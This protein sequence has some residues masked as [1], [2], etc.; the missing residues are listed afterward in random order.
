MDH[1]GMSNLK[2]MIGQLF[3]IG[4]EGTSLSEEE[5]NL[6]HE[7]NVGFVILFSRNFSSPV[8]LRKL[9]LEIHKLTSPPPAIFIDQEGGPIVRLGESGSTVIS[10]MGLAATGKKKNAKIAGKLIG[11]DMR[12]LGIDG[13]FAPVLD[14]NSKKDN[15]VIGIRSFSDD[16]VIVSEYGKEFYRGLKKVKILGCGKHFPGHGHTSADS[17]LEIPVSEIDSKFLSQVNLSPF[18]RLI[19]TG[20]DS[21]MTA[22]VRFPLISEKIS[23]FSHEITVNLLRESLGFKGVLFSDCI[24][25]MAIK[26]NYSS[27]DIIEGFNISSLDVISVSHSL[28]LQKEL[29]EMMKCNVENGNIS[30]SRVQKSLERILSLKKSI[31]KST[32]FERLKNKKLRR[33]IRIEKKIAGESITV[34]K[35]NGGLIPINRS[36]NILIVDQ[37]KNTHSA[38][39]MNKKDENSLQSIGDRYFSECEI[40]ITENDYNLNEIEKRKILK[41]DHIIIFDHSW[42]NTPDITLTESILKLRNDSIFVCANNPYT[43]EYFSS[44][45][46]IV[47]TYGSRHIQIEALFNVLS[48]KIKPKGKLPVTISEHFPIGSG[49]N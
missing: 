36:R 29:I 44:A 42:K 27:E 17:H 6:I 8:Q 13:V 26:D 18:R 39:I 25:M 49:I 46:A 14:V 7:E 20:I 45:G 22:H 10:H 41:Y 4:I 48:G 28:T 15:P 37:G 47:L 38:N 32:I 19:D 34:L 40:L 43:A 33:K 3:M 21:L 31:K 23:T 5:K 11:Q 16:P 2:N 1:S 30:Y 12:V 35:N 24:E 9:T